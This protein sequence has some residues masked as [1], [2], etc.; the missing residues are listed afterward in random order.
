MWLMA[1]AALWWTSGAP[2]RNR[3]P[4]PPHFGQLERPPAPRAPAAAPAAGLVRPGEQEQ[5]VPGRDGQADE[6]VS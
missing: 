3:V 5:A 6:Q 1:M 4:V 2:I